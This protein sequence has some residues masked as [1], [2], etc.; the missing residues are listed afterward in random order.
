MN[1]LTFLREAPYESL[2]IITEGSRLVGKEGT[3]FAV[4][5]ELWH[6]AGWLRSHE[7]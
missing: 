5:A 6:A 7:R 3:H 4:P 1:A 2:E